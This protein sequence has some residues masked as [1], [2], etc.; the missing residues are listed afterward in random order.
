MMVGIEGERE[1]VLASVSRTATRD[2]KR[3]YGF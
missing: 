3:E 2:Q 1:T